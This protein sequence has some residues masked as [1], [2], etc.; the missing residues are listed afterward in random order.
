MAE[1]FVFAERCV[2]VGFTIALII[3]CVKLARRDLTRAQKWVVVSLCLFALGNAYTGLAFMDRP[4]TLRSVLELMALYAGARAVRWANRN[5]DRRMREHG[6]IR[7]I[8]P[9]EY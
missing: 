3:A 7:R 9:K 4:I 2:C 8:H 6:D 5:I 1:W